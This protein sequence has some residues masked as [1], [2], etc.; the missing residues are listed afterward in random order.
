V[1]PKTHKRFL[2]YRE[3]HGYFGKKLKLLSMDEFAKA[4]AELAALET[5]GERRDDEE[6]ARYVELCRDLLRD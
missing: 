2:D 5:K 1:D 6:E 4:D 3:R